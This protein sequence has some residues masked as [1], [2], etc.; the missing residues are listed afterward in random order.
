MSV[1][2]ANKKA[3]IE[4]ADYHYRMADVPTD[5][6]SLYKRL[7]DEEYTKCIHYSIGWHQQGDV[8]CLARLAFSLVRNSEYAEIVSQGEGYMHQAAGMGSDLACR[9]VGWWYLNGKHGCI[10]VRSLCE[11]WWTKA[12]N[13]C[14]HRQ[15]C[16]GELQELS[17]NFSKEFKKNISDGAVKEET[18]VVKTEG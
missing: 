11:M 3:R 4:Y 12:Y 14:P 16:T 18:V 17:Q 15:L 8:K 9:E 7:P 1:D 6:H 2:G 13:H 5:Y 10:K